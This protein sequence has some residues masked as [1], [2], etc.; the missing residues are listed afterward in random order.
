MSQRRLETNYCTRRALVKGNAGSWGV[1]WPDCQ[2]L[3]HEADGAERH[4]PRPSQGTFSNDAYEVRV[5]LCY[6]QLQ[7]FGELRNHHL[8]V[9]YAQEPLRDA[10]DARHERKVAYGVLCTDTDYIEKACSRHSTK[11]RFVRE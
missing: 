7:T 6:R 10:N 2:V 1:L 8:D 5:P 9:L 3:H 4:P 11:G